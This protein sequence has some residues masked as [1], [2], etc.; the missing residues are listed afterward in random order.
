MDIDRVRVLKKLEKSFKG[1]FSSLSPT[2]RSKH[3]RLMRIRP[4]ETGNDLYQLNKKTRAGRGDRSIYIFQPDELNI[5]SISRSDSTKPIDHFPED[6]LRLKLIEVSIDAT[7][8]IGFLK[9]FDQLLI[10]F[11]K[12]GLTRAPRQG[13][14]CALSLLSWIGGLGMRALEPASLLRSEKLKDM[15]YLNSREKRCLKQFCFVSL[16]QYGCRGLP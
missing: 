13:G 9:N 2:Q 11:L 3:L 14:I 7:N 15:A 10:Q 4:F 1:H 16:T 8:L 5:I 6:Q 12:Q